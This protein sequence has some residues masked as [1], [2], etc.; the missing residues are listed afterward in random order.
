MLL[1]IKLFIMI[2]LVQRMNLYA[3]L[4]KQGR[5]FKER[6]EWEALFEEFSIPRKDSWSFDQQWLD[7][8]QESLP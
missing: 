2:T 4:R 5:S 6:R 1:V 8:L 3:P 7:L